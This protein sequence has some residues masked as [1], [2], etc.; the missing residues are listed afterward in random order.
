MTPE[1]REWIKSN[2]SLIF[3]KLQQRQ[4]EIQQK[5]V[6]AVVMINA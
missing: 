3:A 4:L 2:Q 5:A 1:R 6:P